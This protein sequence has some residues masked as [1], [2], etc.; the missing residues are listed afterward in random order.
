MEWLKAVAP[1]LLM[2][3]WVG[4]NV[5]VANDGDAWGIATGEDPHPM[6]AWPHKMQITFTGYSG[7][8]LTDFPV[9]VTLTNGMGN[10][11][12]DYSQLTSPSGYDLRFTSADGATLLP[13]EFDT[14]NLSGTSCIW[15]KVPTLAGSGVAAIW[16][17][18]GN[19]SET[20]QQDYTRD[21]STWSANFRGVWHM[22]ETSGTITDTTANPNNGTLSGSAT[23]GQD[24]AIGRSISVAGGA[25]NA[26]NCGN[27]ASLN[28]GSGPFTLS[29]WVNA[30]GTQ[31]QDFSG[32]VGKLAGTTGYS[33]QLYTHQRLRA[34]VNG[35]SGFSSTTGI[36]NGSWRHLAVTRSSDGLIELFVDGVKDS[37]S[38]TNAADTANAANLFI[39]NYAASVNNNFTGGMD[40]IRI[41][42]TRHSADW[43][44]AEFD[45]VINHGD[46]QTYDEGLV[47]TSTT[48]TTTTS[49]TSTT[50]G[51]TYYVRTDG[52]DLWDGLSAM[53]L[54]GTNGPKAS[55]LHA[56]NA[57]NAAPA[58]YHTVD[59][60]AGSHFSFNSSPSRT[61]RIRGAGVGQ[62]QITSASWSSSLY[63]FNIS[64]VVDATADEPLLFRGF[65][66]VNTNAINGN[67]ILAG[68][69]MPN[70]VRFENVS[71]DNFAGLEYGIRVNN[72]TPGGI[73]NTDWIFRGFS[74]TN[75]VTAPPNWLFLRSNAN[76]PSPRTQRWVF[77][78]A[79]ITDN[80]N[81]YGSMT[82]GR[83][84]VEG[85]RLTNSTWSRNANNGAYG[86]NGS[87]TTDFT[88][89]NRIDDSVI[90]DNNGYG[91][92][93][94]RMG[95][96]ADL[97]IANAIIRDTP[98]G[99]AQCTQVHLT[100][101]TNNTIGQIRVVNTVFDSL[102]G[103]GTSYGLYILDDGAVQTRPIELKNVV[104]NN[105]GTGL[106]IGG[107]NAGL[108]Y[109]DPTQSGATIGG[110]GMLVSGGRMTYYGDANLDGVVDVR[111]TESVILG[112]PITSGATWATG[113]FDFDG[114]FDA[115]D[116]AWLPPL[117]GLQ[118]I[119][120]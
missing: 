102:G 8:A 43:I 73:G 30:S 15:V 7:A 101:P 35:S 91:V 80:G 66:F 1:A 109:I 10:G 46:F 84:V 47:I 13:Y 18:W 60:G 21:G 33:L 100:I 28:L 106:F 41:A 36:N 63:H 9:L 22:G 90:E 75:I 20:N 4:V 117:E 14:W 2:T 93:A 116:L 70:H 62:T 94:P 86:L 104:F 76:N 114:D 79:T 59:I 81:I 69:G 83:W 48:S 72:N 11:T 52:N 67:I 27:H 78:Q 85:F 71:A 105:C 50:A 57:A 82:D 108:W 99:H 38:F 19:P 61:M 34:W 49:S 24:G 98:A 23:Y 110:G 96:G 64:A 103:C 29:A 37:V 54:G 58:G 42:A 113:D 55:I 120:K 87:T 44:K 32:I 107:A 17:Y 111:D 31:A 77:D 89:R 115:D 65:T 88:G 74:A 26:F 56:V 39:G 53:H 112:Y 97:I 118:L 119:V 25:I 95:T 5:G 12:F 51:N 45:N 40:E 6:E 3:V 68:G 16:A 92:W